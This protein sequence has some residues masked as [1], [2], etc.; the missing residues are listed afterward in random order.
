MKGTKTVGILGGMGPYATAMF[1]QNILELTPAE[2]DWDHLRIIIDNNPHIPSRTRAILYGEE[3]PVRRMIESCK[4]L[5]SYPVQFIVLPS[6][7]ACYFLPEVQRKIKPPILSI[8]NIAVEE[9]QS[10]YLGVEKVAVVGGMVT[11]IKESYRESLA[12]K[13]IHLIKYDEKTQGM[14]VTLI[15]KIKLNEAKSVLDGLYLDIIERIK[16]GNIDGIIL[17]CT[18]LTHFRD[19]DIGIPVVDS[20]YAL[21]YRTVQIASGK[22]GMPFDSNKVFDFW[23]KRAKMLKEKKVT[24]F[25]STLLTSNPEAAEKRDKFEK[26]KIL[27]VLKKFDHHFNGLALELGC[28]VGRISELFS[29]YFQH[30]DALDYCEEFINV[31][32]ENSRRRCINNIDYY[33]SNFK[34][35]SSN[36]IYDCI[37]SSGLIEYLSDEDFLQLV[38]MIDNNIKDDGFCFLRESVGVDERLNLHGFY[39]KTLDW[40]YNAAYRTSDEICEQ[41]REH[42]FTVKYE[43]MTMPPTKEKPE[44]CQKILIFQKQ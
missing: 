13:D 36:K 25:Q 32:R 1:F 33:V 29:K 12:R 40:D 6:N 20:S 21:A 44:T 31:A 16:N 24:P 2:K 39:S 37:I 15:E 42:G 14:I 43:E 8:I 5:A 22:M 23:S 9:M 17:A 4:K 35:F 38:K 27:N 26:E 30:I 7:S 19:V 28:G 11:Y 18:E 34:N 3:S 41:F 10:K